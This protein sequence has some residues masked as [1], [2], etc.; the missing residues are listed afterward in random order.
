M[1]LSNVSFAGGSTIVG[2]G[3][4][5]ADCKKKAYFIDRLEY[6]IENEWTD[7]QV[8]STSGDFKKDISTT[9]FAIVRDYSLSTADA[10]ELFKAI[11]NLSFLQRYLS[12]PYQGVTNLSSVEMHLRTQDIKLGK[13]V[14]AF[15]QN[16]NCE[17]VPVAT[18]ITRSQAEYFDM[19]EAC[20]EISAKHCL[21]V[22]RL[23]FKELSKRDQ[24]CLITHELLRLVPK[25]YSSEEEL[26][27]V[28][29]KY[30]SL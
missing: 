16:N 14:T 30:C 19:D 24:R 22:D 13:K 27:T 17:L 4:F 7:V 28:T 20:I 6:L 10:Q 23:L 15:L 9:A 5:I 2:D 29:M 26:R 8:Q 25:S 3:G 21:V 11:K 12:N 18:K 1:F